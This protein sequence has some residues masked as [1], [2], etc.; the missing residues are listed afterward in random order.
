MYLTVLSVGLQ[1]VCVLQVTEFQQEHYVENF[2]QATFNAL[3]QDHL[4]GEHRN[5]CT[6]NTVYFKN[7]LLGNQEHCM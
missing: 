5:L 3:P 6:A 4:Q 7:Q 1:R 2:V